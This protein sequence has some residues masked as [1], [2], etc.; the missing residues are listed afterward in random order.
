MRDRHSRRRALAVIPP[1]AVLLASM[2]LSQTPATG[3]PPGAPW[4]MVRD[5]AALPATQARPPLPYVMLP[6]RP[7]PAGPGLPPAP[8]PPAA[9]P[10]SVLALGEA[11]LPLF[12]QALAGDGEAAKPW[13]WPPLRP[14]AFPGHGMPGG[15]GFG[16]TGGRHGGGHGSPGGGAG[17]PP[18]GGGGSGGAPGGGGSG[19]PPGGGGGSGGAPDTAPSPVPSVTL[20]DTD[21]PTHSP[22]A[23]DPPAPDPVT[24]DPPPLIA[25]SLPDPAPAEQDDPPGMI[26]AVP[27]PASL[28]L[29][30]LALLGFAAARRLSR[31]GA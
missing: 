9:A 17:G 3:G 31:A 26:A 23:H 2:L 4:M 21:P 20:A 11:M 5:I 29:L 10:D 19:G 24:D 8:E 1:A 22:L 6:A 15:G 18:G 28:A 7:R 27:E 25:A 14:A 16:P 12:T 13:D 30:G